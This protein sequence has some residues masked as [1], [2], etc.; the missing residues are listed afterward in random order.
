MLSPRRRPRTSE[1]RWPTFSRG[2][3]M[4][5]HFRSHLVFVAVSLAGA[6]SCGHGDQSPTAVASPTP[7]P[8]ASATPA[9]VPTP[10]L[11]GMSSCARLP[12]VT[13]DVGNCPLEDPNFMPQVL[14]AIDQVRRQ[15]P[16]I[17]TEAGGNTLVT[18]P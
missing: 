17:F 15:Q 7:V 3:S 10:S 13:Q 8:A 18:S 11:P 1:A 12:L 5:S 2:E 14:T 4:K 6:L 9:P 16:E